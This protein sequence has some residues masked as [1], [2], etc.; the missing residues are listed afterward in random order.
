MP[1]RVPQP[2]SQRDRYRCVAVL[3]DEFVEYSE[4]AEQVAVASYLYDGAAKSARRLGKDY[5]AL[6]YYSNAPIRECELLLKLSRRQRGYALQGLRR[7]GLVSPEGVWRHED[8][9]YFRPGTYR[10]HVAEEFM[11]KGRTIVFGSRHPEKRGQQPL[12]TFTPIYGWMLL[13]VGS[14]DELFLLAFMVRKYRATGRYTLTLANSYIRKHLGLSSYAIRKAL[15][16]LQRRKLIRVVQKRG[17]A[18]KVVLSERLRDLVLEHA[19]RASEAAE[20]GRWVGP[21]AERR[22][23]KLAPRGIESVTSGSW[24]RLAAM[25][26]VDEDVG[27]YEYYEPPIENT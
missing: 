27:R 17:E 21:P 1:Y 15:R 18:R 13:E 19:R 4:T 2:S 23:G 5:N 24:Y 11:V 9:D 10:Y 26:R 3:Y 14:S 6:G 8:S 12:E 25:A 16:G 20:Q 22:R 7:K